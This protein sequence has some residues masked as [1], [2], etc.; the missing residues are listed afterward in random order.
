MPAQ[1][2]LSPEES[3]IAAII[4]EGLRID[5]PDYLTFPC[6]RQWCDT[7]GLNASAMYK[8][9]NGVG[10][11]STIPYK[12]VAVC[13]HLPE[14]QRSASGATCRHRLKAET[15]QH[16]LG[17]EVDRTVLTAQLDREFYQ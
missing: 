8:R 2:A 14:R 1:T 15:W 5:G 16:D 17:L 10:W 11:H 3:L 13:T 9:A 7:A 6:G 4:G 12:A